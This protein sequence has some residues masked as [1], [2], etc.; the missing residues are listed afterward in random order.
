MQTKLDVKAFILEN[1]LYGQDDN[2]LS[3]DISFLEKGI[4]DSTGVLEL[5]S[6]IEEKYGIS[7]DDEE[8]IP[9][10]LDSVNKLSAFIDRRAGNG[11]K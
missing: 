8:M 3:D 10:N 6:F 2:S 5:V 11:K 4:I 9:D 1:F 7:V